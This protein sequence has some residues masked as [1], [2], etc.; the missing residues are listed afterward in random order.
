MVNDLPILK[1]LQAELEKLDREYRIDL[2]RQIQEAAAQGDLSDNAEYQDAKQRQELARARIVHLKERLSSLS[3][4]NVSSI[5]RGQAGFGSTVTLENDEDGA[6]KVY[7]LVL[8]EEVDAAAGKISVRSPVGQAIV[9]REE[10]DE[11]TIR[12]PG[13]TS[14]YTISRLVTIHDTNE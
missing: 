5:P 12:T 8:P 9:G 6:E 2:P 7:H 14:S 4:I 3:L 10:G 11:V 1:K 13:G